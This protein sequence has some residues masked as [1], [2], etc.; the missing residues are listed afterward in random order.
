[1][2]CSSSSPSSEPSRGGS[3]KPAGNAKKGKG[4]VS[5]KVEWGYFDLLGRGDSFTQM[6]E[7][8]GQPH[9]KKCYSQ[10]EWGALKAA[11]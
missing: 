11:G 3:A 9:T 2:G 4:I 7:Y 6:F 8:H 1:M 5:P 10:E